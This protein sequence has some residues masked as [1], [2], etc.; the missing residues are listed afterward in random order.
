MAL[1]PFLK[2]LEALLSI[3]V[4]LARSF[5]RTMPRKMPDSLRL[6]SHNRFIAVYLQQ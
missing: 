6:V 1:K 3:A 2:R 5:C 4:R